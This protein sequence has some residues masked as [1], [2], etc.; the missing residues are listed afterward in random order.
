MVKKEVVAKRVDES[1]VWAVIAY[2]LGIIGFLIVLL[3]KK[4]DTFAVYHAK[5][6][7]VLFIAWVIVHVIGVFVPFVG[8][9]VWLLG[10]LFLFIL[11]IIGIV[12]A[13]TGKEKPLPVI[14]QFGEK[15]KL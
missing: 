7:L 4:D 9:I 2:V 13:A 12:N 8:W 1:K 6:A 11:W 5:Q 14:G 3:A 10:V 15:I